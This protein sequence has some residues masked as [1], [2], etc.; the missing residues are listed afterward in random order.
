M[1]GRWSGNRRYG[2]PRPQQGA[3]PET[4]GFRQRRAPARKTPV[5]RSA[6]DG[7]RYGL[8]GG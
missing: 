1:V 4:A 6:A 2:V 3:P 8:H 5:T 7:W